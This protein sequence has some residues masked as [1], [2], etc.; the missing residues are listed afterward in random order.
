[1]SQKLVTAVTRSSLFRW[2]SSLSVPILGQVM[3]PATRQYFTLLYGILNWQT[4]EFRYVP[5]GPPGPVY[6]SSSE[7]P[8]ILETNSFP[9]GFFRG[10]KY[11]E[12]SITMK[13]ADR[14]YLY[15]DGITE[16]TNIDG[17]QFGK[18]RLLRALVE[19]RP[20]PLNTSLSSLLATVK[21]WCGAARL[22]DDISI[23]ALEITQ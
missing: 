6:L 14:L 1:M 3:D 4:R 11:E 23:L 20:M 17:E 13:P 18:E 8:M 15:S 22:E 5:A 10:V 19:S 2:E 21:E 9:I 12:Y 16:A 7:G